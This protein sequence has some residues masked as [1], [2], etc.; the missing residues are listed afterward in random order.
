MH[1]LRT[2]FVVASLLA[3]ASA[4]GA[5]E[6]RAAGLHELTA[7]GRNIELYVPANLPARPAAVLA[8]HWSTAHG[9]NMLDHW[10][11]VADRDGV[12]LVLPSSKQRRQW[13]KGDAAAIDRVLGRILADYRVDRDRVYVTGFSGG[14][15]MAYRFFFTH[16]NVFAGI[17]PYA[18]RM[19]VRPGE[20]EALAHSRPIKACVVHGRADRKIPFRESVKAVRELQRA[21][22]D[23]SLRA[24][25]S[26]HWPEP[27]HAEPMWRCL[28]GYRAGG[29]S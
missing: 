5:A 16:P 29:Q 25:G 12:L 15:S 13:T 28:D 27:D 10:K 8:F 24:L 21:G 9:R 11:T 2:A 3:L 14:A 4:A 23:A 6:P 20:L 1:G 19:R 7:E 26:G 17:G 18:G 22:I